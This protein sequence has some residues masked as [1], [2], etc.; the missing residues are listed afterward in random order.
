MQNI[1]II[2][3][4]P[5]SHIHPLLPPALPL[6]PLRLASSRIK[7][8]T[9]S[10]SP[11]TPPSLLAPATIYPS[12]PSNSSGVT[13]PGLPSGANRGLKGLSAPPR[14]GLEART[15]AAM[16]SRWWW[17][18]CFCASEY[19][20]LCARGDIGGCGEVAEALES[21]MVFVLEGWFEG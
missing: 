17:K 19:N 13:G 10:T 1:T 5:N 20:L 16:F 4:A 14:P 15:A 21:G 6:L 18:S 8:S 3:S 9:N 12:S 2:N 11:P 7:L